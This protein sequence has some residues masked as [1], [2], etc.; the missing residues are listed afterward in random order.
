M[1]STP[2]DLGLVPSQLRDR[3]TEGKIF[4]GG[5]GNEITE[6]D[7]KAYFSRYGELTDVVIM[8]DKITR[9]GCVCVRVG[10]VVC[11]FVCVVVCVC[12]R[13][14]EM[15]VEYKKIQ[16]NYQINFLSTMYACY[17]VYMYMYSE[18]CMHVYS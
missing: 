10:V 2:P 4:V 12:V 6:I 7:L 18:Q 15:V 14:S 9:N 13:L 11:V 8:R 1:A 16:S 5:L 17:Y 3:S